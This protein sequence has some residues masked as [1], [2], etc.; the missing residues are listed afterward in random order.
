MKDGENVKDRLKRKP[1]GI[2]LK[3]VLLMTFQ[4]AVSNLKWKHVDEG[5]FIKCHDK[6]IS[7]IDEGDMNKIS[8]YNYEEVEVLEGGIK[9]ES[10]VIREVCRIKEILA[11]LGGSTCLLYESL[12]R[13]ELMQLSVGILKA[14]EVDEWVNIADNVVVTAIVDSIKKMAKPNFGSPKIKSTDDAFVKANLEATERRL[15]EGYQEVETTKKKR[16]V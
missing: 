8:N 16:A 2:N 1:S 6:V 11:N 3:K 12:R 15:Q 9:E 10:K 4:D 14:T 5:V 13:L 7:S